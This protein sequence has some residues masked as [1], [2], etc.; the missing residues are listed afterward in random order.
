V[1]EGS[2]ERVTIMSSSDRD[3]R[4]KMLNHKE[5]IA[6]INY[7]QA[8]RDLS[9]TPLYADGQPNPT[10]HHFLSHKSVEERTEYCVP[11]PYVLRAALVPFR[12]LWLVNEPSRFQNVCNV[13][14]KHHAP[15][16]MV[17]I[18]PQTEF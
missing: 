2:G 8:I 15:I 6:L 1:G 14:S 16:S 7:L 17:R 13:L 10:A 4:A 5:V 12:K 18:L 3:I 9:A 11:D